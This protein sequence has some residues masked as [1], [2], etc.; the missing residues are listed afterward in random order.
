M[1]RE[2]TAYSPGKL[3]WHGARNAA[4]GR[5]IGIVCMIE[6]VG[7]VAMNLLF[8][9]LTVGAL[10]ARRLRARWQPSPLVVMLCAIVWATSLVQALMEYGSNTRFNVPT[11][12]L[13]AYVVVVSAA[14]VIA[15]RRRPDDVPDGATCR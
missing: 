7:F 11:Q 2:R 13:V 3:R 9:L 1:S 15:A 14:S 6:C 5:I 10:R 12:P 8:L 4:I